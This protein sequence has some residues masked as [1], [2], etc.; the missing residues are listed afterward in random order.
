VLSEEDLAFLQQ[1]FG[2]KI[3]LV[4]KAL[5]LEAQAKS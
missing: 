5:L 1:V 2:G 3:G 4:V